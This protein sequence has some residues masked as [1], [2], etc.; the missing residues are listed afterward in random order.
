MRIDFA[1]VV[2]ELA[3]MPMPTPAETMG[4]VQ[5]MVE[6]AAENYDDEAIECLVE[7]AG[8]ICTNDDVKTA[9]KFAVWLADNGPVLKS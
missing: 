3:V 7:L 5:S 2:R 6:D 1:K 4:A 8:F 9:R